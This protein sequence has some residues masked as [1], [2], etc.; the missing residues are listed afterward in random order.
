MRDPHIQVRTVTEQIQTIL[1]EVYTSA[2]TVPLYAGVIFVDDS[3]TTGIEDGTLPN[4]FNTIAEGL[5]AAAAGRLVF[6]FGGDYNESVNIVRSVLLIGEGFGL[7]GGSGFGSGEFPVVTGLGST[8]QGATIRVQGAAGANNVTI[9]GLDISNT[10]GF[11]APAGGGGLPSILAGVVDDATAVLVGNT[12]TFD[13]AGNIVRNTPLGLVQWHLGAPA[14]GSRIAQNT[15][16]GNGAAVTT[17]A[18]DSSGTTRILNNDMTDNIAGVIAAAGRIASPTACTVT[19]EI[20]GNWIEG[21]G[22]EALLNPFLSGLSLPWLSA[23]PQLPEFGGVGILGLTGGD[24]TATYAIENNFV[25]DNIVGL[26]G[27]E[28]LGANATYSV[29]DNV[30]FDNAIGTALIAIDGAVLDFTIERNLYWGGLLSELVNPFLPAG[31]TMPY[32]DLMG[33]FVG[34]FSLG[35][36]PSAVTGTIADNWIYDHLI[37]IGTLAAG[38]NATLDLTIDYNE[39]SGSGLGVLSSI[40]AGDIATFLAANPGLVGA[41][42]ALGIPP[43]PVLI[44]DNYGLAGIASGSIFGAQ[45]TLTIT[46]NALDYF[47]LSAAMV[48]WQ[49]G[50]IGLTLTD[51]TAHGGSVWWAGAGGA[52]APITESG[53]DFPLTE[54]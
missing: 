47:A 29:L 52:V 46:D 42:G 23:A 50:T 18:V 38:P 20:A 17:V 32:T 1:S 26:A 40:P 49:G 34:S 13:F 14:F 2:A 8:G 24:M 12:T 21:A 48:A 37:G 45:T 51:N 22:I 44:S 5:A 41:L 3:N 6:V 30:F 33:I 9:R 54:L 35:G 11:D 39:L 16:E 4:P 53:N 28:F 7:G 27:I 43:V 19:H 36:T 15:F 31:V 25:V 10:G